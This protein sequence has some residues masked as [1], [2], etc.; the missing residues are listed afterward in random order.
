MD[1]SRAPD[2]KSLAAVADGGVVLAFFGRRSVVRGIKTSFAAEGGAA[3][4]YLVTIGP[5]VEEH[6]ERPTVYRPRDLESDLVIDDSR[7]CRFA[8]STAHQHL[9][10]EAVDSEENPGIVLLD[11]ERLIMRVANFGRAGPKQIAYLDLASG[12]FVDPPAGER[13]L[14]VDRWQLLGEDENGNP[15]VLYA[16]PRE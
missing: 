12:A 3:E 2:A 7:G 11:G 4:P 14:A 15:A 9:S 5:F 8:L 16:F 1:I 13:A 6:G 10:L